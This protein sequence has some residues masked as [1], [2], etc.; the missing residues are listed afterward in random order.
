[1]PRV[2]NHSVFTVGGV[3]ANWR[4]KRNVG[5]KNSARESLQDPLQQFF[6]P[7]SEAQTL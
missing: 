6:Y 3:A 4:T 7:P 5:S 1:M 2:F